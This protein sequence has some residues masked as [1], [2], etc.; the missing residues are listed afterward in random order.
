MRRGTGADR[1][2]A[3]YEERHDLRDVVDTII[4]ETEYGIL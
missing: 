4:E 2:V 3:K 1:Q